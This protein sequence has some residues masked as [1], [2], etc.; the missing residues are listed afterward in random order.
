MGAPIK[1]SEVQLSIK[2]HLELEQI[3]VN[4]DFEYNFYVRKE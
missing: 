4:N 3:I 2:K 1:M